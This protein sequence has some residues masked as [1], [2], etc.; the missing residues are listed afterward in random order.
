[1]KS[2]ATRASRASSTMSAFSNP[3]MMYQGNVMITIPRSNMPMPRR[4]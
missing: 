2:R 3:G 4:R 1:M